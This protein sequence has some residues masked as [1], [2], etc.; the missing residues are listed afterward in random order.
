M[1]LHRASVRDPDAATH[2]HMHRRQHSTRLGGTV[3][4]FGPSTPT[5]DKMQRR[6]HSTF[7]CMSLSGCKREREIMCCGVR[8]RSLASSQC[9]ERCFIYLEPFS[10]LPDAQLPVLTLRLRA[11]LICR[12][13]FGSTRM[14]STRSIDGGRD[15]L[16]LRS[17]SCIVLLAV[18]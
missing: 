15:S 4:A 8:Q 18:R 12:P 14:C 5:R 10:R 11:A 17:M 2:S 9:A 1:T 6:T 7:Q 16:V 13:W 3:D